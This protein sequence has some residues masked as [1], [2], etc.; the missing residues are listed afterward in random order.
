MSKLDRYDKGVEAAV[1]IRQ[2]LK[3]ELDPDKDDVEEVIDLLIGDD[4]VHLEDDK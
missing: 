1:R 2:A 3:F 4:K